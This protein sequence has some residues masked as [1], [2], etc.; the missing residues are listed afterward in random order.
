MENISVCKRYYLDWG[1]M[2]LA[3]MTLDKTLIEF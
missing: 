3:E 1:T 2:L